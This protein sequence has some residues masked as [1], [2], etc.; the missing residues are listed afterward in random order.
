[1]R[2]YIALFL[3]FALIASADEGACTND[4]YGTVENGKYGYAACD[5]TLDGYKFAL[6][7]DGSFGA[8]DTSKCVGRTVTVFSY[9]IE[10]V[11]YKVGDVVSAI[12]LKT[13]GLFTSYAIS[14]SLPQ[15]MTFDSATGVIAG[16][17]SVASPEATYTITGTPS[18]S[19]A[20]ASTTTITITVNAIVCAAFDSFPE[21]ADGQIATSTTACPTGYSGTAK[22]TCTNGHFG[23]LDTTSC[24]QNGPS[25]FYYTQ[26]SISVNRLEHVMTTPSYS[27][28]ANSFSVSPALP[29][30]ISL[31]PTTGVISGV[32]TVV[33][34]QRTYT[35]TA[36]GPSGTTPAERSISITVNNAKC[37]GLVDK[38]ASAPTKNHN[39]QI[40][41]D[42][43][44]GY[45]GNWSYT[46]SDG[47]YKNKNTDTCYPSKPTGFSYAQGDYAVI[48]GETIN[49][50]VPTITGIVSYYE[51]PDLPEGFTI[52]RDTG[53]IVG[54]S[55]VPI[56][57]S[58]TVTAVASDIYMQKATCTVHIVVS[59]VTCESTEDLKTAPKGESSTYKCP[60]GYKEG[61]M[62]RKC[63][64]INN[65]G[66]FDLPDVHCQKEQDYT[67]II[68]CV[69]ILVVCLIVL[70][71][72]CCVNSGRKRSK[73]KKTLPKSTKASTTKPVAKAAPKKVQ[74]VTI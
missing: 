61:S 43:D 65:K 3:I 13:D 52:D 29:T 22:R 56:D 47:V 34:T 71:I 32:P 5:I 44:D 26:T 21:T 2:M 48:F 66:V 42:C 37:S 30:G 51:A 60:E 74:K 8:D 7:T 50:G 10:T 17:P 53:V 70:L 28:T 38:T 20:E 27:G 59:D 15:G 45:L 31:N 63:K 23:D 54:S 41:F 16:T 64:N 9:G 18:T 36:T 12:S 35:V 57:A 72:G 14:P 46:C 73:D 11:S 40:T 33:S 67:F 39:E 55:E 4:T 25:N 6:C 1:M 62:K 58:V 49:T 69:V 68:I 24:T 19:G